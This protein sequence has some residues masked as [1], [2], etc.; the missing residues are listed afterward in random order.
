[1]INI[2]LAFMEFLLNYVLWLN[3]AMGRFFTANVTPHGH[4]AEIPAISGYNSAKEKA[5]VFQTTSLTFSRICSF[6]KKIG[7]TALPDA[8]P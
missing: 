7:R 4:Y 1:M 3:E 2:C 8:E 5:I 6:A